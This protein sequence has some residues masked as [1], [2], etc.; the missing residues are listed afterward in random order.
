MKDSY[1][2]RKDQRYQG[3]NPQKKARDSWGKDRESRVIEYERFLS[4]TERPTIPGSESSKKARE[5]RC[6]DRESRVIEYERFL[7]DMERPT[8][9]GLESSKKARESWGKDRESRVTEYERFLS[10]T[11]RPTIPGS[12]SSKKARE[13]W[14]KDRESRVIE[15][16]GMKDSYLIWKDQRYQS[17]NPQRKQKK[18]FVSHHRVRKY[19][20]Y[21]ARDLWQKKI[22]NKERGGERERE[23]EKGEEKQRRWSKGKWSMAKGVRRFS[24]LAIFICR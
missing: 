8:I 17:R 4:D 20:R 14:G 19:Q 18:V 1:L 3:R 13:S 22:W 7:S 11:E 2:I 24:I 21:Q 16:R 12:E 23:R 15:G 6:K 5:S 10:D 9:P